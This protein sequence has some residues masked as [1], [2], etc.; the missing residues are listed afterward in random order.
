MS[1][2][3]AGKTFADFELGREIGRG[4]MGIVYEARQISLGRLVALKILPMSAIRSMKSYTLAMATCGW[5]PIWRASLYTD[6]TAQRGNSVLQMARR[7]W[8]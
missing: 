4:G 6:P 5:R 8:V 1:D 7:F 2:E 3:H